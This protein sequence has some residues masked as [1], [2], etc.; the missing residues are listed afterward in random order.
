M[1]YVW[2]GVAVL[3]FA[4]IWGASRLLGLWGDDISPRYTLYALPTAISQLRGLEHDYSAYHEVAGPF[5]YSSLPINEKI[6]AGF[7]NVLTQPDAR[8]YVSGDDKGLSDL[9]LSA[10]LLYS[11]KVTSLHKMV[12]LLFAIS[13]AVY[14]SEFWQDGAKMV[15]MTAVLAGVYA[16]MFTFKMNSQSTSFIE[17]RFIGFVSVVALLH[18]LLADRISWQVIVQ[19]AFVIAALHF[20]SSEIWQVICVVAAFLVRKK[21][22][23]PAILIVAML[24]LAAYRHATYNP[25]YFERDIQTR[26][27][28]HNA[29]IG[30]GVNAQLRNS[31]GLGNLNDEAVVAAVR[32]NS[33]MEFGNTGGNFKDFNW[34]EYEPQARAL[35]V[36]ILR[37]QPLQ[38]A[39]TYFVTVPI[40]YARQVMNLPVW[41]VELLALALACALIFCATW[42][43]II[44]PTVAFAFSLIPPALATPTYQYMQL[45][46]VLLMAIVFLAITVLFVKMKKLTIHGLARHQG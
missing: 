43:I 37:E 26:V 44:A 18:L 11:A 23:I 36:R 30:L 22:A 33:G 14:C 6:E 28:F 38:V 8:W 5:I 7:R 40:E 42:R 27:I 32:G 31:Y 24:A 20:R 3:M 19:A 29:L 21:I 15:A 34:A 12:L 13:I 1:R 39:K 35:Y 9:A 17:P 16:V 45:S 25:R 4:S 41:R 2:A 10:L 46:V